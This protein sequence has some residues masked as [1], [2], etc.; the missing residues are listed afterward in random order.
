[1]SEQMPANVGEDILRIHRVLTR[2]LTVSI[3]FLQQAEQPDNLHHGFYLPD[4]LS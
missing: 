1:M 3:Q 4:S 2:S